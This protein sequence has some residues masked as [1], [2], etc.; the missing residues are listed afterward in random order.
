[1]HKME[2]AGV[3]TS[4]FSLLTFPFVQEAVN[5]NQLGLHGA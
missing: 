4:L 2:Q 1:M 5:S 3:G